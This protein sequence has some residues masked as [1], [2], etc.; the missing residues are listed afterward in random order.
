V[1]RLA[2]VVLAVFG[3]SFGPWLRFGQL[4]VVSFRWRAET[5]ALS[6]CCKVS[7]ASLA[8]ACKQQAA[9]RLLGI[10]TNHQKLR[11]LLMGSAVSSPR[12]WPGCSP[13]GG[14]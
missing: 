11:L 13:L 12:C 10:D 2:A 8:S 3:L 5:V 7:T 6:C 4:R 1:G 14:A 9:M